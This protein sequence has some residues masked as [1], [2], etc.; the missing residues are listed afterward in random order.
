M[1]LLSH[2]GIRLQNYCFGFLTWV[3]TQFLWVCFVSETVFVPAGEGELYAFV[4]NCQ[5]LQDNLTLKN[6]SPTLK[7]RWYKLRTEAF[8]TSQ[9]LSAQRFLSHHVRISLSLACQIK[10]GATC[11]DLHI[12]D[13]RQRAD[14]AQGV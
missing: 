11:F 7:N 13:R 1:F 2:I 10:R 8:R 12:P 4:M 5:C 9:N 14:H 6:R 3:I